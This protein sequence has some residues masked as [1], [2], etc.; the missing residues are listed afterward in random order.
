MLIDMDTCDVLPLGDAGLNTNHA[1]E[2]NC[3]IRVAVARVAWAAQVRA[4]LTLSNGSVV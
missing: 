1:R 3:S 2:R 4:A